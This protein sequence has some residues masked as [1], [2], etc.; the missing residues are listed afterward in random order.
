MPPAMETGPGLIP[1][2]PDERDRAWGLCATAVG[3]GRTPAGS[4]M[5]GWRL[6]YVVR[7][8]AVLSI[9]RRGRQPVESGDV[10]LLDASPGVSFR[11]DHRRGCLAHQIDFTG[12]QMERHAAD[13]FFAPLPTL[14]RAGFDEHLLGLVAQIIELARMRPPGVGRMVAGVLGNLL[15]RLEVVHRLGNGADR[16]RR[17][18]QE[19]RMMLVDPSHDRYA[20]QTLAGEL[21]VGYSW[22]RRSFRDQTGL[23]PHQFRLNQRLVR[24]QQMLADTALPVARIASEL[25]FSSQAYFARLF[26]RKTG[27]SPSVWR[28]NQ[29]SVPRG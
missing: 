4:P 20:L 25:G 29:P 2:I 11:P 1:L 27:L 5:A 10:V 15:A 24:A 18:V 26:R 28:R 23:A 3:Q 21:G 17:L 6:Y 7:G 22:F 9:P 19:A 16:Q 13:G 8:A 14:I 12:T